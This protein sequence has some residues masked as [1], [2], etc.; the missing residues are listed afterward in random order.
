MMGECRKK[1]RKKEA[2]RSRKTERKKECRNKLD[3]HFLRSSYHRC[4]VIGKP[5]R[6]LLNFMQQVKKD[7]NPKTLKS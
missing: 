7:N 3:F 5:G 2:E 4:T 1:D 6:G